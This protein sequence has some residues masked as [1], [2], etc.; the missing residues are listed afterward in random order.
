[1]NKPRVLIRI[2]TAR[3]LRPE[4]ALTRLCE[5]MPGAV[6]LSAL[7][8]TQEPTCRARLRGHCGVLV[9]N[10][11]ISLFNLVFT[12]VFTLSPRKVLN[13][14]NIRSRNF[15]SSGGK[16]TET[17]GSDPTFS[18]FSRPK[19][20]VGSL[21]PVLCATQNHTT[22]CESRARQSAVP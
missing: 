17:G 7:S 2:A 4:Q 5:L 10:V 20:F 16:T 11:R 1:M 13:E 14:R 3:P 21:P 19:S 6:L 12:Q 22:N 9:K 8:L 15:K 18:A